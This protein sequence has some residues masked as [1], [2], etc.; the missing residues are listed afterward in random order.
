MKEISYLKSFKVQDD[1]DDDDD[2]EDEPNHDDSDKQIETK[3][4]PKRFKPNVQRLSSTSRRT[5]KKKN[6]FHFIKYAIENASVRS[7]HVNMRPCYG[8]D[9]TP[10]S[11]HLLD[12][13]VNSFIETTLPRIRPPRHDFHASIFN[14]TNCAFFL[15]LVTFF[16]RFGKSALP[17]FL[18]YYKN[19]NKLFERKPKFLFLMLTTA[20]VYP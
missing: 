13:K 9:I 7:S 19:M 16:F 17:N 11:G 20:A 14:W 4:R 3:S 18:L 15:V 6:Y 8:F 1:D 10:S 5:C 2:D 12:T